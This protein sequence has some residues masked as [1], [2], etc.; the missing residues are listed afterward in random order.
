MGT[1]TTAGNA[2]QLMSVD[3]TINGADLDASYT[4]DLQRRLVTSSQLVSGSPVARRFAYDRWGN[5]TGMWNAVS[6][7]TQIQSV[8]LEQTSGIPTNR[9]ASVT[10]NSVTAN[11]VYDDAGNVTD[12]D[13][14]T[15]S[16]D[17]ENRLV[18]VDGGS[19]ATYV[20]DHQNRRVKTASGSSTH[21]VWEGYQ[22][23]AE[24]NASTGAVLIDY[25]YA[26]SQMI[27]KEDS[28]H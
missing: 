15:Y 1:D 4:Y 16:Y 3:G 11:Y 17:A 26:G 8:T 24:H 23:L 18:S 27:A 22:V 6:G 14:H 25:V 7:G 21:Y 20:Y 19:T 2:D 28:T 9:L 5:R 13:S 10:T 12:D